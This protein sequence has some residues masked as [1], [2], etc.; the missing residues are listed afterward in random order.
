MLVCSEWIDS[1]P[2]KQKKVQ[3][4][5]SLYMFRENA[6]KT[7]CRTFWRISK[8]WTS[9]L[10]TR[11]MNSFIKL[12]HIS[13]VLTSLRARL[14]LRQPRLCLLR[15]KLPS[16]AT[17]RGFKPPCLRLARNILWWGRELNNG[18]ERDYSM[19]WWFDLTL[20]AL[21][22][23]GVSMVFILLPPGRALIQ[24]RAPIYFVLRQ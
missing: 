14:V 20:G 22:Y 4:F 2:N 16:L 8:D 21:P 18:C 24:N 19:R 1:R 15:N 23:D 9:I 13:S 17:S 7:L 6:L 3:M 11:R 12:Y 10:T 5:S